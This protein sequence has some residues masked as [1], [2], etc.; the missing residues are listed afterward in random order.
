MSQP[1]RRLTLDDVVLDQNPGGRS[2]NAVPGKAKN[3]TKLSPFALGSDLASG[4]G[5]GF[6]PSI[7]SLPELGLPTEQR[8]EVHDSVWKASLITPTLCPQKASPAESAMC[9]PTHMQVAR[10]FGFQIFNQSAPSTKPSGGIR[11]PGAPRW[12]PAT[13]FV[14][15]DHLCAL[16]RDGFL[17]RLQMADLR[18]SAESPAAR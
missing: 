2:P 14:A 8:D 10:L 12:T 5:T 15:G 3:A 4:P 1:V 17:R 16:L 9:P 7:A 6:E 18:D 13:A 11:S